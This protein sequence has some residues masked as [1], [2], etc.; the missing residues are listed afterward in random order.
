[1]AS[2]IRD[3]ASG[4]RPRPT[5]TGGRD[6]VVPGAER[7][8]LLIVSAYPDESLDGLL[9]DLYTTEQEPDAGSALAAVR[10]RVPDLIL[11]DVGG[12]APDGLALLDAIRK[13]AATRTVP[14]ILISDSWREEAVIE[15]L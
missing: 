4:L 5:P 14:F 10:R 9:R 11:A 6:E 8:R 12:D 13:D 1:M 7:E 2:V 15:A 3:A